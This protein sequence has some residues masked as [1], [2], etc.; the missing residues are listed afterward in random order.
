MAVLD[1]IPT[2]SENAE[3]MRAKRREVLAFLDEAHANGNKKDIRSWESMLRKL[4]K[5]M[6][7]YGMDRNA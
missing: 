2:A 5:L 4:D 3:M 7:D 1:H 6:A